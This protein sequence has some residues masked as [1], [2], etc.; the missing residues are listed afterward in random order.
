MGAGAG[1]G[2]EVVN[3]K[4]ADC[5]IWWGRAE[6]LLQGQRWNYDPAGWE[7]DAAV[8][9]EDGRRCWEGLSHRE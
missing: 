6:F 3:R 2:S 4:A 8:L 5:R 1:Q 9:A 7:V